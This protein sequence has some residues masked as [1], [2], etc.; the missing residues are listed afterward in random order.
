A[1]QVV[2]WLGAL[3]ATQ[4][5]A[6]AA[7]SRANLRGI[8]QAIKLYHNACG[9]YPAS[10]T[11]LVAHGECT[12]P[13]FICRADKY[14]TEARPGEPIPHTSYIYSPGAGEWREDEDIV[15]AHER[16]PWSVAPNGAIFWRPAYGVLFAD[17]HTEYIDWEEFSGVW[18]RSLDRRREIG[19]PTG[20]E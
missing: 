2:L 8:G 1:V 11:D 20:A 3:A 13:Q 17:L 4:A 19:W 14:I 6:K 5:A 7:V 18:Y 15:L 10:F 16:C 12:L 9:D